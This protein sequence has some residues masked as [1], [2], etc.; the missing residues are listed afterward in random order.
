MGCEPSWLLR[1]VQDFRYSPQFLEERVNKVKEMQDEG[2]L[3][4]VKPW[5]LRCKTDILERFE[6]Y[7]Y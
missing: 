2:I 5:M 1:D 6:T 3:D 4:P 7:Y